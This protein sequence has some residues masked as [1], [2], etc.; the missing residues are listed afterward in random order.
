MQYSMVKLW[1]FWKYSGKTIAGDT[2]SLMIRDGN[3]TNSFYQTVNTSGT[4][5]P[6]FTL[7]VML[8]FISDTGHWT[9]N[10][11]C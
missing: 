6:I 10:R 5:I 3:H 8:M 11:Y 4:S 9:D 1:C 7:S 2:D